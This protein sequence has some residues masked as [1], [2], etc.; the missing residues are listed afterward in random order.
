MTY[1]PPAPGQLCREPGCRFQASTRPSGP[2]ADSFDGRC[3]WCRGNSKCDARPRGKK[4]ENLAARSTLCRPCAERK[5]PGKI[6][7]MD[8]WRTPE[9]ATLRVV[10]DKANRGVQWEAREGQLIGRLGGYLI[11]LQC[12]GEAV[13][14]MMKGES[15]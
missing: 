4:C 7:Y 8:R 10:T 2:W 14:Q 3:E 11:A 13:L 9:E 15:T 12:D 6:F 1:G 5:H